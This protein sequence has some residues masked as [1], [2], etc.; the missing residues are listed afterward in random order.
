M[1]QASALTR[2]RQAPARP[3]NSCQD[4]G[5]TS[6]R[7]IIE[8]DSEGLMKPSGRYACTGCKRE[9]AR[10]DEWRGH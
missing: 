9:F 6:Y 7:T 5:A 4:C 3:L 8:R 1:P 2:V 10:I